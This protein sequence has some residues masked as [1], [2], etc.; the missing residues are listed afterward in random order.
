MSNIYPGKLAIL[1]RV[2]PAYRAPFFDLLAESCQGGLSLY[3]GQPRPNESI[4]TAPVL[5]IADY[6]RGHNLHLLSGPLYLCWQAGLRKWLETRD[7]QALI[8]E[9]NPR[10]LSTPPAMRWMKARSRPVIGWGLGSP[11]IQGEL[12][13]LRQ[14]RRQA[15]IRQFDALLTY[16]QRGAVEYRELGYPP[17][18]I[19]V[20][21][22]AVSP[23]PAHPAPQRLLHFNDKPCLL[24]VGRLQSR[25]R[26]DLL[27]R[28][29]AGLPEGIQPRLV[30]VGDGPER[31]SLE[32]LAGQI[33]PSAEFPG[34]IH[35]PDLIPYYLAADLFV[36]PGTGGLA[37]QQAM[38]QA[39]PV[40]VAEGD[41]TQADL[42]RPTNGWQI[43]PGDLAA[44][45]KAIQ[46]AISDLPRL[47]R[48]GLESYRIVSEEINL[49][50]M[51][52]VFV[53]VASRFSQPR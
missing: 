19:F 53:E 6:T 14:S 23:R 2:L 34:A 46:I 12:A 42:V 10:Y 44:L 3:A 11:P 28:A 40:I 7:P 39:L 31:S 45:L 36:L 17:E 51:V 49:E 25:K 8:V 24:F 22:N 50:G 35:G 41:G 1:Q 5:K 27:L 47:R 48:K 32:Q 9:A 20:A 21:P 29:C 30:V 38:S 18:K 33:Y 43:P 52:D 37:V 4:E 15:F 16:S 13:G 26:V